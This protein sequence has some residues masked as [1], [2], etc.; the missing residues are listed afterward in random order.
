MTYK[1]LADGSI[2]RIADGAIIP[3][4]QGNLDYR[5]FLAWEQRGNTPEPTDEPPPPPPDYR[6]LLNDLLGG[7][8]YQKVLQQSS[9]SLP[10]NT[11]FTALTGALIL[12]AL[13]QPN[14][15]AIAAAFSDL[16]LVAE[17]TEED[18]AQ[19]DGALNSVGAAD[20]SPRR[21]PTSPGRPG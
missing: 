16:L 4:D 15:A 1:L 17:T 7:E 21:R 6:Q 20:L 2:R 18:L 9:T 14:E 10:V 8:L 19:L 13:G 3:P 5:E 11:A 12:A